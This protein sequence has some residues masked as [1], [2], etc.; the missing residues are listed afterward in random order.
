MHCDT[1]KNQ[2]VNI[3]RASLKKNAALNMTKTVMSVIFPL[4][5][6]PYSSRILGPACI[7]KVNFAQSIVS[8]FSLVAGLGIGTYAVREA[9]KIRN[10]KRQLSVFIKEVFSINMIS[11]AAAYSLFALAFFCVPLF[12]DYRA[13]LCVC[14]SSILFSTLGMDYLYTALEEFKYITV[15]SIA[16]QFLSLILLFTLVHSPD[17]YL[18]YAG[19]SVISSVGS[20]LLN[21]FHARR[22]I[23]FKVH[24][25]NLKKHLKSVFTM[26]AMSAAVSI[27]TVLDTTM[28][29][30]LKGDEA[31]GFYSA[32]TKL[33]KIVLMLIT[34]ATSVLL[35]RLS[36]YAEKNKAEFFNLSN[37]ALKFVI[38]F[39][40]PCAAGLFVLSEP[41]VLLFSGAQFLPAVPVMKIMNA[42]IVLIGISGVIGI[43]IFMS[44]NKERYTLFSVLLGAAVN[45]TL[46][47]IF[48]PR[49]G[50]AGAAAATVCAE[51]SVT[52]LQ[53]F[54]AR[55]Y[56]DHKK[57]ILHTAKVLFSSLVMFCAVFFISEIFNSSK[58]KIIF[59]V[60][61]GFLIYSLCMFFLKN[62]LFLE[63]LRQIQGRFIKNKK[64]MN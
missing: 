60:L 58:L 26:F 2:N 56:F 17:D 21:F 57:V 14:A 5:T 37:K 41:V 19:V 33:N 35:P 12:K 53:V 11:T 62:S 61:S 55:K 7:G 28:L 18:K 25:E 13:L 27:Y 32:A 44:V 51:F 54:L 45:F 38:M 29:G 47:M 30:F 34:A 43:Q 63:I 24:I 22:F 4:I 20:N 31:V 10:E 1:G 39:S 52:A 15:R 8:Y 6:F 48:I 36:F 9:A 16:F 50:A 59:G 3:P 23:D 42:V 46:N 40:V 49:Y 64:E